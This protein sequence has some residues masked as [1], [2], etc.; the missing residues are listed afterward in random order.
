MTAIEAMRSANRERRSVLPLPLRLAGRQM[1]AGFDGFIIFM[2]CVALGVMVITGV[3]TLADSLNLGLERHGRT[4]LGG[5]IAIS[6]MHTRANSEE[7]TILDRVGK[8]SETATMRIMARLPD[9]SDQMLAELKSVDGAYPLAGRLE[10]SGGASLSDALRDNGAAVEPILL[11]RLGLKVGDKITVGQTQLEI[12]AAIEKEPEGLIDRL[13][14]GPRVLVSITTLQNTGLIQ[15]G[16]LVRWRYALALGPDRETQKDLLDAHEA[17]KAGLSNGGFTIGDRRNP[18]PEI[19]KALDRL[20][21]FLT[22]LGLAALIVGGV[23][24]ANAVA[25]FVDRRRR[26]IATMRA[27]GA[28]SRQIFAAFLAQILA[29]AAIGIAIGLVAG[30]LIPAVLQA[31]YGHLLPLPA[32]L[33]VSPMS[34]AAAAG[35][36]LLVSLLFSIWPLGRAEQIS[37]AVL[38][39]DEVGN[40]TGLPSVPIMITTGGL[41]LALGAIAILSANTSK[42]ALYFCGALVAVLLV[43]YAL[44]LVVT[45]AAGKIPR[46]KLPELAIAIGNIGSPGGLTRSIILSL[47]AGL[48]LLVA[49]ALTDASLVEELNGKLP[50]NAPDY[51]VLDIPKTEISTFRDNILAREPGA[52]VKEAPMLRGRL[53]KL[54]D[55]PVE[56]IKAPP[57]AEWVLRGDRGIT[58]SA[59]VPDGSRVTAGEWWPADYSGEPLVSFEADL[60]KLLNLSIGDTVTVNVLG[61]N[62]TARI[63]NVR[64]L[65]WDS[66]S[67]NFVMVFSPNTLAG[68]PNNML[69]TI[70]L[71]DNVD[72][73]QEAALAKSVAQ[74]FPTATVIRVRDA[75]TAFNDV[76][77]KII[78][79]IRI[80]SGVTL[81]AGALV[82]AGSL[83]TAQRRRILEAV[84]LKALGATRRRILLAHAIEYTLLGLLTAGFAIALG[85]MSAELALTQV[86]DVPFFFSFQ[87]VLEAIGIALGLIL[88]FGG[89]GT[90]QVLRARPVPYLRSQ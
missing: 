50:E 6:R 57:D 38:F 67:I 13:T 37:P 88:I 42:I 23:G 43:F 10:L 65:D 64:E 46:S 29:I 33:T 72:V 21:Q 1:R 73:K 32:E 80:A 74:S 26:T 34:L 86:I 83:A 77:A 52:T 14:Y 35:Y 17:L 54:G 55:R 69:A 47:G 4:I 59:E 11:E 31:Q 71:P 25:Q 82:L 84:I 16:A 81:L 2:L 27:I 78:T 89:L 15:P 3:G 79:A 60:A 9:G 49:V 87:A 36:G 56:S 70:A 41:A 7:R 5:D 75:I 58:Y 85:T 62:I 28:T 20:R 39:R 44:G 48:S 30:I 66:L 90:W 45:W 22:L 53:I 61:R 12:R 51:F 19:R 18:S 8:I 24:I 76:F 63:A 40:T 68:A